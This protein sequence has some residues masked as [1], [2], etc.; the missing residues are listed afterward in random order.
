MCVC[1]DG[2]AGGGEIFSAVILFV[3]ERESVCVCVFILVCSFF[4]LERRFLMTEE[5]CKYKFF[6][7][8]LL[9]LSRTF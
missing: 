1:C 5:G 9:V 3:S 6:V 7:F 4:T 8:F 2:G